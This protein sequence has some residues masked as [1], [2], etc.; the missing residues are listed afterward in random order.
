MRNETCDS[1]TC[2][3]CQLT[4][5]G[6]ATCNL[7]AFPAQR[8]SCYIC[9]GTRNSTCGILS[10]DDSTIHTQLCPIFREDDSC[11]S[12][13]A[14]GNVTRGCASSIPAGRCNHGVCG[15]CRGFNCNSEDFDLLSSA[16]S[17]QIGI[18]LLA[19]AIATLA[20]KYI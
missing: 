12:T 20:L 8:L 7:D 17:V 1:E 14:A 4:G 16:Y 2:Q 13:R 11:F 18:K 3:T 5:I 6:S 10:R 9:D 19:L 15:F